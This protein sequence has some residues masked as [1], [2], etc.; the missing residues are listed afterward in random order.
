MTPF[1]VANGLK[2]FSTDKERCF[3]GMPAVELNGGKFQGK[4]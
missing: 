1:H 2:P 3:P 4:V